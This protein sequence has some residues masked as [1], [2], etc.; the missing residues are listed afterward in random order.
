MENNMK[1][2]NFYLE[3]DWI[4][5][6]KHLAADLDTNMSQI[7]RNAIKEHVG[8]RADKYVEKDNEPE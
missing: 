7:I 5:R 4:K 1:L 8:K 6:L 2:V 3:V